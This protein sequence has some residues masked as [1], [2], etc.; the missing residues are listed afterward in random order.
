M[1]LEDLSFCLLISYH[2][3]LST[4]IT[5]SLHIRDLVRSHRSSEK[6][7]KRAINTQIRATETPTDFP[8]SK[9][10]KIEK[11]VQVQIVATT[12]D[13]NFHKNR[14]VDDVIIFRLCHL[15]QIST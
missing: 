1:D 4:F 3:I 11:V 10:P 9:L 7:T 15:Y 13:K 8:P 5:Y 6:S 2:L 14:I 12:H